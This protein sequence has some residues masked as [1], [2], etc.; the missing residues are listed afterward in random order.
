MI[1]EDERLRH[2]DHLVTMISMTVIQIF[3]TPGSLI[4]QLLIFNLLV[5]AVVLSV[6]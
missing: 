1:R 2:L 6:I 4:K 3:L 5:L